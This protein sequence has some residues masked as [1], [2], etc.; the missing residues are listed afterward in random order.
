L[1]TA[2]GY[3]SQDIPTWVNLGEMNLPTDLL[4]GNIHAFAV[5]QLP[6]ILTEVVVGK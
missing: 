2:V 5:A 6:Q 4:G 1:A 3:A